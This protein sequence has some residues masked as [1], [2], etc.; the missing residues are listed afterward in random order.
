MYINC[1]VCLISKGGDVV[2]SNFY[3][4]ETEKWLLK[5]VQI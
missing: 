3:K 1:E 5:F 4:N 2:G